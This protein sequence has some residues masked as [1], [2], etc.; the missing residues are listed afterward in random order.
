LDIETLCTKGYANKLNGGVRDV[1]A[2][3]KRAIFQE[4]FGLVPQDKGDYEIDH[5]ISLEL[6]GSNDSKNLWPESYLTE[7]YNAHVKDKLEDH[8]AS[9]VHK[10]FLVNGP[11]NAMILLRSFQ[12]EIS[13]NW[14]V[15]YET[16]LGTNSYSQTQTS[17]NR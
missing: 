16:L 12:M 13:T 2:K 4:Y 15:A 7:P 8:M 5:L 10:E 3:E 6:G 17:T 11:T 1:S 14:I 9:L